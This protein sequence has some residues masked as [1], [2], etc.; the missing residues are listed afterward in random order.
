MT[1]NRSLQFCLALSR[2]TATLTR[3][4]DG[5][6]GMW[7]GIS[8]NDLAILIEL[9]DAPEGRLRRVDLAEHLGVTASGVTRALIPLEKIGL[10]TR[11]H[12]VSDARVSYASLTAA[13]RRLADDYVASAEIISEDLVPV[14]DDTAA[15][16][17]AV[18][19]R[20]SNREPVRSTARRTAR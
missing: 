3:R 4:F 15:E 7:H 14:D 10:V 16:C 11:K 20:L 19:D 13:G 1:T 5:K 8:L 6:L 9:R 12:D 18:F 17:I 2:A